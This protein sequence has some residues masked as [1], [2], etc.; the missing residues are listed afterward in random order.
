MLKHCPS[1][2]AD[3]QSVGGVSSACPWS[4]GAQIHNVFE[5]IDLKSKAG[6]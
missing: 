4:R 2:C 1:E 3:Y 6:I 5:C